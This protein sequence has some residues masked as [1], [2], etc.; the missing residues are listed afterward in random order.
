MV[1]R[2]VGRTWAFTEVSAL[3]EPLLKHGPRQV[4]VTFSDVT[5]DDPALLRRWQFRNKFDI[6]GQAAFDF[7]YW[8]HENNLGINLGLQILITEKF[9]ST[10]LLLDQAAPGNGE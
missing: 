1:K 4:G 2:A 5:F 9:R 10:G 6:R 8:L 3:T 7:V